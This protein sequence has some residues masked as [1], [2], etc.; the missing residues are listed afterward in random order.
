MTTL[1]V[2]PKTSR[3]CYTPATSE[4]ILDRVGLGLGLD[5]TELPGINLGRYGQDQHKCAAAAWRW[6]DNERPSWRSA[7]CLASAS[8]RPPP[9]LPAQAHG[10]HKVESTWWELPADGTPSATTIDHTIVYDATAT[11][12]SIVEA[13][14]EG[15]SIVIDSKRVNLIASRAIRLVAA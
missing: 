9:P 3:R 8:P 12:S 15:L 10:S 4:R 13:N 14:C 1:L 11:A 5:S 2:L 7:I 6:L